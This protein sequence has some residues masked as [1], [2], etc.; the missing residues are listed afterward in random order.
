MVHVRLVAADS[1]TDST[2]VATDSSV[3][4]PLAMSASEATTSAATAPNPIAPEGKEIAWAAGSFIVLLVLM[5][6]FLFPKVKKG[7]DARYADI[8]SNIEGA[9]QVK[10]AARSDVADYQK[11]LD[12]IRAE[13]AA[14]IDQARQTVDAERQAKLAEVNG[15]IAAR[16]AETDAANKAARDAAR[17]QIAAA[18][19]QVATRAAE[20]ASGKAPD[21]AVVQQAVAAAMESAG[22]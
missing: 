7:M 15:R 4:T 5:R 10:A 3:A 18:V 11:A 22:N 2:V 1:T 19:T 12:G 6:Y 8:R 20:L 14:K 21:A 13:A 16:R 17:G 9:D